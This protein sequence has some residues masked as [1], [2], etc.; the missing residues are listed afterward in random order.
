MGTDKAAADNSSTDQTPGYA[1]A[2]AEL[3]GIL[4]DLEDDGIDIDLLAEK[5]ERATILIKL[6]RGRI[7]AARVQVDRVVADLE[8]VSA[9][10][11]GTLL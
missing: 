1:A 11:P 5:V 6:C 8:T 9:D 3:E 10:E 4:A 2:L 7:S